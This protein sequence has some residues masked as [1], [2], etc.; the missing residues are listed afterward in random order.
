MKHFFSLLTLAGLC[1]FSACQVPN[2]SPAKPG[3]TSA[4]S[5]TN[6]PAE[7]ALGQTATPVAEP[8]ISQTATPAAD[9]P[10]PGVE[11]LVRLSIDNLSQRLNI[12]AGQISV[13]EAIPVIWRDASLG[14]PKP[15][16]DYVRVETPGYS[17]LLQAGDKIYT[18]HTNETNRIVLCRSK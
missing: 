1:L 7:P 6:A 11:H 5:S 4:P 3:P 17:I 14:C 15:G 2:A 13:V 18:Y 12:S 16:I 9:T 8:S 10:A